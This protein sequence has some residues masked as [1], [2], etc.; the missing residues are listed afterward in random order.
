MKY[1]KRIVSLLFTI[2]LA[3][4]YA[5]AQLNVK[6]SSSNEDIICKDM[7]C[8]VRSNSDGEYFLIT[9]DKMQRTNATLT[10][11]LGNDTQSALLT[12]SDL[13]NWFDGAEN[14]SSLIITDTKSGEDLTLYRVSQGTY[15]ITNGDAEYARHSYNQALTTALVGGV[16]QQNNS[17][18]PILGYV[19]PKVLKKAISTLSN[20]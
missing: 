14:K 15:I 6:S 20:L 13:F 10:I 12:L 17:S 9:V 8:S 11:F 7:Y 18:S 19:T 4:V 2:A 1:M 5:N 16:K 3:S